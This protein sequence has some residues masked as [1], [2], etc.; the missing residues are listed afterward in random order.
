MIVRIL[1]VIRS[2][3]DP[4]SLSITSHNVAMLRGN[5]TAISIIK[6]ILDTGRS[7]RGRVRIDRRQWGKGDIP[8]GRATERKMLQD[9]RIVLVAVTRSPG[10]S[11]AM[12]MAHERWNEGVSC[13]GL[14][15]HATHGAKAPDPALQQG[16]A[17][18]HHEWLTEE[19]R[20][21]SN[22]TQGFRCPRRPHPLPACP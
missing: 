1:W 9:E 16:R 19:I 14:S 2:K 6:L 20:G 8:L 11:R 3:S 7:D 15:N 4:S 12:T 18:D 10:L 17:F 22:G 5:Y 13:A 21:A